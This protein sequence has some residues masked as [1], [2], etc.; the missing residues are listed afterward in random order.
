[1]PDAPNSANDDAYRLWLAATVEGPNV[2]RTRASTSAG[3]L[4]AF[5]AA[6][7]A[8]LLVKRPGPVDTALNEIV[9]ATAGLYILAVILLV[10]ATVYPSRKGLEFKTADYADAII[11]YCHREAKPL[12]WLT[13]IGSGIGALA[14]IGSVVCSA[15]LAMS[16]GMREGDVV[17]VSPD[18]Q[19]ELR[20]ACPKAEFPARV[21]LKE[22]ADGQVELV[23]SKEMCGSKVTFVAAVEDVATVER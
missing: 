9:L 19:K 13:I 8:A 6:L 7:L 22:R 20:L 4:G 12:R 16:D 10:A 11:D 3:L 17:L 21:R 2:W 5:T 14:V 1:M 23:F 18:R 15:A